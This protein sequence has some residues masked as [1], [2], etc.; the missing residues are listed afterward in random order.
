MIQQDIVGIYERLQSEAERQR[1]KHL[2]RFREWLY[3]NKEDLRKASVAA[4][5][6]LT[7]DQCASELINDRIQ[8]IACETVPDQVQDIIQQLRLLKAS[9]VCAVPAPPTAPMPHSSRGV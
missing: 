3:H 7:A 4:R 1:L 8:R 2:H 9:R 6:E 5:I